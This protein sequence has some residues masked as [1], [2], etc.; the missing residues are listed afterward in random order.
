MSFKIV[1][2]ITGAGDF[3]TETFQVM[4]E[5]AETQDNLE[6]TIVLSKAA[7]RVVK[8]YK[9]W[10]K[11]GNISRKV[12]VEE[13]ANTPFIAGPLQLGKFKF[14]C[15]APATGNTVAKIV[16][17]IADTIIT[18]AVAQ[19]NKAKVDVYV[20]PVD[21]RVGTISTILP[22]GDK[23]ELTTRDIDIENTAKLRGMEGIH[24]LERPDEIRAVLNKHYKKH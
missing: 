14:L 9:L 21:G 8:W 1:W 11:I 16:N 23:L 22:S 15:V 13:D 2:G 5:L 19:A 3:L 12:L 4:R 7:E 24:V 20:L 10:D 17:G 18:N 6:I